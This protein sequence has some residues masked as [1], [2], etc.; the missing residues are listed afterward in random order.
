MATITPNQPTAPGIAGGIAPGLFV[1]PARNENPILPIPSPIPQLQNIGKTLDIGN[2]DCPVGNVYINSTVY[3]PLNR[4]NLIGPREFRYQTE[5]NDL[6]ILGRSK[7]SYYN[8]FRV[9]IGY[10]PFRIYAWS[11]GIKFENNNTSSYISNLVTP[12]E[13]SLKIVSLRGSIQLLDKPTE[14][15]LYIERGY[16][17]IILKYADG[18]TFLYL[19]KGNSQYCDLRTDGTLSR[20][21]LYNNQNSATLSASFYPKLDFILQ[22]MD[23]EGLL[24]I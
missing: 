23:G 4:R 20:L 13:N 17:N 3:N 16:G 12:W 15:S 7:E 6:Y 24:Q 11:Q 18:V 19:S 1:I 21:T 10:D 22:V 14:G 9:E 8:D 5:A 2:V